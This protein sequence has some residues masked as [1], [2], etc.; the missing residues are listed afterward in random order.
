[1]QK[2]LVLGIRL[3]PNRII[4]NIDGQQV[5]TIRTAGEQKTIQ[6]TLFSVPRDGTG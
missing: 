1:V 3:N 6:F 4:G 5:L 2:S